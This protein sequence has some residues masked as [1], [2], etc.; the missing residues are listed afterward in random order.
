MFH[1]S[2]K[3]FTIVELVVVI[4]VVAVLVAVLIPTFASII[5][6][7]HESNALNTANGLI[8]SLL[9]ELV[10]EDSDT[11]IIIFSENGGKIYVY[12]FS[13]TNRQI[14]AYKNIPCRDMGDKSFSDN[15]SE[16]LAEMTSNA[17]IV[18]LNP[19]PSGDDWKVPEKTTQ[20][21][22]ESGFDSNTTSVRADFIINNSFFG[23]EEPDGEQPE[24]PDE[25]VTGLFISIPEISIV[26][27]TNLVIKVALLPAGKVATADDVDWTSSNESNV[28]V[29]ENG[30]IEAIGAAGSTADITA[31]TK[32]GKFSA[33]CKVT[34]VAQSAQQFNISLDQSVP[35]NDY[36]YFVA[37]ETFRLT[38]DSETPVTWRCDESLIEIGEDGSFKCLKVCTTII[39]ATNETGA[40]SY[41][42]ANIVGGYQGYYHPLQSGKELKIGGTPG[43]I[44]IFNDPNNAGEL[45]VEVADESKAQYV[46]ITPDAANTSCRK[47]Y[48]VSANENSMGQSIM[49][50]VTYKYA[51]EEVADGF[52]GQTQTQN[53]EFTVPDTRILFDT[54]ENFNSSVAKFVGDRDLVKHIVF[55][56]SSNNNGTVEVDYGIGSKVAMDSKFEVNDVLNHDNMKAYWDS[57]SGTLYIASEQKIIA[58]K[59]MDRMFGDNM[60][61]N[62]AYKKMLT[63]D[64][65]NFH[66]TTAES[67][68]KGM[69][70][71]CSSLEKIYVHDASINWA[72]LIKSATSAF[73]GCDA[74]RESEDDPKIDSI[75]PKQNYM[76]VGNYTD[77]MNTSYN[78]AFSVRAAD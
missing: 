19:A 57:E 3:G 37:G 28:T 14:R 4:V 22:E 73:D 74:L 18:A 41:F 52:T 17:D 69:F 53:Y 40:S 65:Y 70:G 43:R 33:T 35:A 31:T 26:H 8:K 6:K 48:Y 78:G 16:I 54:G 36:P 24:T 42:M 34:V 50:S 66:V 49:V 25:E 39:T 46:T 77:S 5:A 15:V 20:M 60:G 38:T 63:I 11:D 45:T 75:L 64:L 61:G 13:H 27:K 55:G 76:C 56:Y 59:S 72:T 51:E 1:N 12:G 32:D 71:Y 10:G 30:M 23:V 29:D 44:I 62:T 9:P 2:K 58:P 68:A 67:T 7:S 47:V 21:L